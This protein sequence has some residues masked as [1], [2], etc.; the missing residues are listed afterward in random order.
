MR[1]R[2]LLAVVGGA[3]GAP[4]TS[5]PVLSPLLVDAS[6]ALG[7]GTF[8][9]LGVLEGFE[10]G[11]VGGSD[12]GGGLAW[13]DYDGDGDLDLYVSNGPGFADALF[14]NDGSGTF[15][16]VANDAGVDD[17]GGGLGVTT[18]DLDNDGCAD[19][20]VGGDGGITKIVD[21]PTRLFWNNCDGTFTEGA[22]AANVVP[23]RRAT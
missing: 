12:G 19:V 11:L 2:L 16:D 13:F 9:R 21:T 22:A 3:Y 23:P 6:S 17:G 5:A 15:E 1:G 20:L 18:A 10:A 7:G 8:Q 14:A 4:P